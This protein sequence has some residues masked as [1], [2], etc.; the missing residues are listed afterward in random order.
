MEYQF[1]QRALE[2]ARLGQGRV[3]PNPM[4]GCVIVKDNLIIGEGWHREYGGPHAEVMALE[5]V[6]D[7]ASV[8]GSD[9][10]VNLEP[11]SHY[12]KTPPCADLLIRYAVGRVFISNKDINPLVQGK[13]IL[14]LREAGIQVTENIMAE[15]GRDLNRRFFT[16]HQYDRPYIILK[17]AQT[18]DGYIARE[19][20]DARWIS[21][22]YSRQIVHKWRNEEDAIMVGANTVIYDDPQLNV[23]DWSG[24]DP[25]RIVVDPHLKTAQT[26]HI[27]DNTQKTLIYNYSKD[28]IEDQVYFIKI[29]QEDLLKD[30]FTDLKNKGIQSVIV[31]GGTILLNHIF[32]R[33][34]WDEARVFFSKQTFGKGLN[35]PAITDSKLS[36]KIS[37]FDDDLYIFKKE[38]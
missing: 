14:K 26:A 13:G 5:E 4:V 17:W 2:L 10:Y 30:M 15:E 9:V 7:K 23:R 27:Y 36:E 18:A 34:Q 20:H 32:D 12:G 37:I 22:E 19:N 1:M 28:K 38:K 21:N 11:C 8:E 29:N 31:E 3:S 6:K 16:F 24:K 33:G 25:V 35:A